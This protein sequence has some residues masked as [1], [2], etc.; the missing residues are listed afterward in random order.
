MTFDLYEEALSRLY[1]A[2]LNPA[3]W[4]AFMDAFAKLVGAGGGTYHLWDVA[5]QRMEFAVMTRNFETS[6]EEVEVYNTH[7]APQDPRRLLVEAARPGT[8]VFDNQHFDRRFVSRS[9]AYQWLIPRE[10]RYTAGVRLVGRSNLASAMGL[11]RADGDSPFGGAEAFWLDRITP[12]IRR[13]SQLHLELA[14]VRVQAALGIDAADSLDYPVMIVDEHARIL[15]SNRA[16]EE[17]LAS[18]TSAVTS[19]QG[20]LVGKT[21]RVHSQLIVALRSATAASGAGTRAFSLRD[22]DGRFPQQVMALPL[23]ADSVLVSHW[24]RPLALV[25]VTDV[26]SS[27]SV[28][29]DTLRELYGLSGAEARVVTALARGDSVAEVAEAH[30]VTLNTIR[31]QMKS[32]FQKTGTHRQGELLTLVNSLP[33]VRR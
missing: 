8:W 14:A 26:A 4:S 9:E 28:G 2:P 1:E 6:E 20:R 33:R 30:Q 22:E 13:A 24:Q 32:V 7:I 17:L 31:T 16:A 3:E 19:S 27:T 5:Q 23:R 11:F 21:S 29:V 15:F 12:H 25:A 10:I 18:D